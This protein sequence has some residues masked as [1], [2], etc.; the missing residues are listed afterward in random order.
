MSISQTW[1]WRRGV[2]SAQCPRDEKQQTVGENPRQLDGWSRAFPSVCSDT[3]IA[4]RLS[5]GSGGEVPG[6]LPVPPRVRI[7]F[8]KRSCSPGPCSQHSAEI[9]SWVFPAPQTACTPVSPGLPLA[10]PP[11]PRC[12]P[13]VPHLATCRSG[14]GSP[15]ALRAQTFP[16]VPLRVQATSPR[17]KEL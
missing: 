6:F 10:V 3:M 8:N 14:R 17:C 13:F 7:I 12:V 15:D 11:A 4:W 5:L 16:C 1:E 2:I 9:N